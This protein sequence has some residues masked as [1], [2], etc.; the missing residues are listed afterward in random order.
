MLA[1]L[2]RGLIVHLNAGGELNRRY[3][4]RQQLHVRRAPDQPCNEFFGR[5]HVPSVLR[6]LADVEAVQRGGGHEEHGRVREV[7]ARAD[8]GSTISAHHPALSLRVPSSVSEERESRVRHVVPDLPVMEEPLWIERLGVRV[9][10]LVA[11]DGP[12]LA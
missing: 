2:N 7:S 3:C 10:R 11:Q 8:P 9:Q 6:M 12:D 1:L 5:R 4:Q